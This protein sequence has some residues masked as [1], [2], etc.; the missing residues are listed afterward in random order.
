MIKFIKINGFWE[1]CFQAVDSIFENA[2]SRD[3]GGIIRR[4]YTDNGLWATTDH[5][6]TLAQNWDTAS[7]HRTAR[8][9][10]ASD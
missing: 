5:D 6:V 3:L 10:I 8:R 4:R 1:A 7:M 9:G 2:V